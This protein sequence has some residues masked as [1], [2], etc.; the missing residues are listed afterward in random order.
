[1]INSASLY[2]LID[3]NCHI[4]IYLCIGPNL[5]KMTKVTMQ[6]K[7]AMRLNLALNTNHN[8]NQNNAW[9]NESDTWWF[10]TSICFIIYGLGTTLHF[11]TCPCGHLYSA[12]TYFKRYF[13]FTCHRKF[14]MNWTSFKRSPVVKDHIF[15]V[16]KV[17]S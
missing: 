12:V 14:H 2:I 9:Q 10:Y 1:M 15:F 5:R 17:T 11:Q 16:P 6:D 3:G 13:F 7:S 4:T 8:I